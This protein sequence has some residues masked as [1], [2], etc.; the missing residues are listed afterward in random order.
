MLMII[1]SSVFSLLL[2]SGLVVL[3]L[4]ILS[5][6]VLT[7]F[8]L[9]GIFVESAVNDS[10]SF[11]RADSQAKKLGKMKTKLKECSLRKVFIHS[12]QVQVKASEQKA[13]EFT[14]PDRGKVI[15]L[16]AA[17]PTTVGGLK[18]VEQSESEP[19]GVIFIKQNGAGETRMTWIPTETLPEGIIED[20]NINAEE[21]ES[22]YTKRTGKLLSQAFS[23]AS[24]LSCG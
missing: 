5:A 6:T 8:A 7:P 1:A 2:V 22:K 16:F 9:A 20:L 19:V 17:K 10:R 3:A 4:S 13:H 14:K 18:D 21:L 23:K 15:P 24:Q 12:P 11:F